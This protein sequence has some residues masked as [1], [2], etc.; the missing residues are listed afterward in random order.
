M[1]TTRL[2]REYDFGHHDSETDVGR[3]LMT[4]LVRSGC[5]AAVGGRTAEPP[6]AQD[7]VLPFS[8]TARIDLHRLRIRTVKVQTPLLDVAVHLVEAKMAGIGERI[9]ANKTI[10]GAT[11]RNHLTIGRKRSKV[12]H[13]LRNQIAKMKGGINGA[14]S[15]GIL[16]LRFR[17]K[18]IETTEGSRETQTEF[19]CLVPSYAVNG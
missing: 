10:A 7:P 5:T 17:R 18:A 2:S 11:G 12:S 3:G 13:L 8:R 16:P 15:T 6:S 4:W 9:H 14:A 1:V 19:P